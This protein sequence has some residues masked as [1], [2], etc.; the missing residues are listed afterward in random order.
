MSGWGESQPVEE[1]EELAYNGIHLHWMKFKEVQSGMKF[2]EVSTY[3]KSRKKTDIE[4]NW[5][6]GL[7]HP[8]SPGSSGKS[9]WASFHTTW[10]CLYTDS[11]CPW[12]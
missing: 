8:N 2:K 5:K 7:R 6:K 1:V 12:T 10:R 4:T 11:K 9:M 3:I